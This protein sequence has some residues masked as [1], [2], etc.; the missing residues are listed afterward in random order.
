MIKLKHKLSIILT[1]YRASF[2]KANRLNVNSKR[3]I[4]APRWP[5]R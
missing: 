3:N 4:T 5:V 2:P 1:L